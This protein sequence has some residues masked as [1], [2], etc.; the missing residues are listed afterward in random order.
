MRATVH[1][2]LLADAIQCQTEMAIA[3]GLIQ[4]WRGLR[5]PLSAVRSPQS[6]AGLLKGL[7]DPTL[8]SLLD[9]PESTTAH[10]VVRT[11]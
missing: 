3:T 9:F 5:C 2:T 1:L 6:E 8:T 10:C 4:S 11:N 7:W